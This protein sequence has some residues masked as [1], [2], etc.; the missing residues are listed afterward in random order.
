MFIL[1]APMLESSAPSSRKYFEPQ[2]IFL[3]Y[4]HK[5]RKLFQSVHEHLS[6]LKREG[7]VAIWSDIELAAGSCLVAEITEQLDS[8]QIIIL[9]ISSS[10]MA[11]DFCCCREMS[12]ALDRQEAGLATVIPVI[13][14]PCNWQA[15]PF[16]K[17]VAL[18]RD[19][20]PVTTWGNRD[21]ALADVA[22]SVRKVLA[23]RAG[24]SALGNEAP[25]KIAEALTGAAGLTVGLDS[26]GNGWADVRFV[27][28]NIGECA[29]SALSVM[30]S[31]PESEGDQTDVFQSAGSGHLGPLDRG[32]AVKI[33]GPP[34]AMEFLWQRSLESSPEKRQFLDQIQIIVRALETVMKIPRNWLFR[35]R[36]TESPTSDWVCELDLEQEVT[37]LRRIIVRKTGNVPPPQ[38]GGEFF[39]EPKYKTPRPLLRDRTPL[40]L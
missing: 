36:F 15:S 7:L 1:V 32:Y 35:F 5:D 24:A 39:L 12:R 23:N 19:A 33:L 27:I 29:L 3:S 17:L 14:R 31:I 25:S 4:S 10:F 40:G 20:K 28:R 38:F 11:S 26:E 37:D 16:A 13:L 18:P 6:P 9:L 8:A 21:S 2:K 30:F 34:K 22:A